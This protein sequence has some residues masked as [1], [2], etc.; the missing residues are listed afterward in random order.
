MAGCP[1]F[2]GRPVGILVLKGKSQGIEA[3]EPLSEKEA[4]SPATLKYLEA[5]RLLKNDDP[6]ARDAFVAL[7]KNFPDDPLAAFHLKR[8]ENGKTGVIVV[9]SEK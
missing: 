5:F 1:G 2:I 7:A 9:L 3:F 4:E 6:G 8:L